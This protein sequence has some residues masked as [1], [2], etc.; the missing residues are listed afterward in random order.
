MAT[1]GS[2]F[3]E[4]NATPQRLVGAIRQLVRAVRPLREADGVPR[5]ELALALRCAQRRPAREDDQPLLVADLVVVRADALPGRQLVHREAEP[6]GADERP[7]ALVA[8]CGSRRG[9]S[10]SYV[11]SRRRGSTLIARRPSSRRRLLAGS[12]AGRPVRQGAC[13]ACR[14]PG[15]RRRTGCARAESMQRRARPTQR[16]ARRRA[17]EGKQTVSPAASSRSPS[18][19]RRVGS[20]A[21]TMSHS[22]TPWW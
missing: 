12:S 1:D 19:V 7:D 17:P 9:S 3:V 14:C 5:A 10:S 11:N 16:R 22:S 8:R 6:L 18:G 4:S 20:P 13:R 2:R 15:R 21:M